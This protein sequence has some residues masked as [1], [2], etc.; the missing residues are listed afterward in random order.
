MMVDFHLLGELWA[1]RGAT[2][3]NETHGATS[4]GLFAA[5]AGHRG[6]WPE[7]Q[8]A[9]TEVNRFSPLDR[10]RLGEAF[11]ADARSLDAERLLSVVRLS[12]FDP[13]VVMRLCWR[14][15]ELAAD[16]DPALKQE[17]CEA[18]ALTW[19]NFFPLAEPN[20][21]AFELAT[22]FQRLGAVP[23]A[24]ELYRRSVVHHGKSFAA[25]FNWALC[26][27]ELGEISTASEAMREA[28]A[29]EPGHARAAELRDELSLLARAA[30][31]P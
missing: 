17:L 10:F 31:R 18:L 15:R 30:P 23:M 8:R 19:K 14:L 5:V 12:R 21:A 1:Q 11:L 16:L 24:A 7:M 28:A 4:L 26:L 6:P 3:F 9:F 25:L 29:L 2:V 22:V 20:D 13:D 27:A